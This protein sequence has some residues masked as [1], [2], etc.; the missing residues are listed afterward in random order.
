[1][2]LVT[3]S[4]P[5][6]PPSLPTRRRT[7]PRVHGSTA[8]V[9]RL[10]REERLRRLNV[11]ATQ[12]VATASSCSVRSW[13]SSTTT[14]RSDFWPSARAVSSSDRG[15]PWPPPAVRS[16]ESVRRRHPSSVLAVAP[17]TVRPVSDQIRGWPAAVSRIRCRVIFRGDLYYDS[18]R[19]V[20]VHLVPRP[21]KAI[22]ATATDR[23]PTSRSSPS[24][25]SK[26]PAYGGPLPPPDLA[27]TL[28]CAAS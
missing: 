15:R 2:T 8:R 10:R 6:S 27:E 20:R 13:R 18:R 14:R 1:M 12:R 9:A 7:R 19:S 26:C 24:S 17:A 16:P 21:R 3:P 22:N 11:A 4:H 5:S 25:P 23:A 28:P